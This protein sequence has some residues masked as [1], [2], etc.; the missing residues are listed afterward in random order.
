MIE[1][2]LSSPISDLN[3]VIETERLIL[4]PITVDHSQKMLGLLSDEALY[5]Y[6]PQNPPSIDSLNKTY[7]L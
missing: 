5:E 2:F 3:L 6:I 1:H 7:G 4:E